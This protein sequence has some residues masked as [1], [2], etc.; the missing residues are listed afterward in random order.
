MYVYIYICMFV[1]LPIPVSNGQKF[2]LPPSCWSIESHAGCLKF[3]RTFTF[4]KG[5]LEFQGSLLSQVHFQGIQVR[6]A[7]SQPEIKKRQ[8][9]FS[10]PLQLA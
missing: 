6:E 1:I 7:V 3:R 8:P 5:Q 2:L 10:P 4:Q 9:E